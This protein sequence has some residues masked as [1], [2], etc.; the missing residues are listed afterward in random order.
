MRSIVSGMVIVAFTA[1]LGLSFLAEVTKEERG[2]VQ[3]KIVAG[4]LQFAPHP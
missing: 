3:V 4:E 1:L 2:S